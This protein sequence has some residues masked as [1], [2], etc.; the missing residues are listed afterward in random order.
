[1]VEIGY[2]LLFSVSLSIPQFAIGHLCYSF[3]F[4]FYFNQRKTFSRVR[5]ILAALGKVQINQNLLSLAQCFFFVSQP[6][7]ENCFSDT[8]L[9]FLLALTIKS[10]TTR[11]L[12]MYRMKHF[13]LSYFYLTLCISARA[14]ENFEASLYLLSLSMSSNISY[15]I[16]NFN[17]IQ[18][19]KFLFPF[20]CTL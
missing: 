8:K 7:L 9:V 13:D 1:M 14:I 5:A 6:F 18:L 19:L 4:I 17:F 10:C 12:S 11:Q 2:F 3:L 20:I 15:F 16:S